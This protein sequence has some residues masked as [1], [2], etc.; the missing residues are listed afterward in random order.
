MREGISKLS[1]CTKDTIK[2]ALKIIGKHG[3]KIAL[4]LKGDK[5]IGILTDADIRHTLESK[6]EK[7]YNKTPICLK[8]GFEHKM[9]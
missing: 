6:N 3:S 1:L 9:P 4:V 7:I 5:F 8:A 2:D